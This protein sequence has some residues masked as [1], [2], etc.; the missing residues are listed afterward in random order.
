MIASFRRLAFSVLAAVLGAGLAQAAEH[1]VIVVEG[2]SFAPAADDGWQVIHQQQSYASHTYGGMWTSQGG[3]L[4]AEAASD[5]AVA[6][7][8]ITVPAAGK[9]RVWSKYQSPPYFNYRHRIEV[10][11]QGKLVFSQDYGAAGTDR[12]WSFSAGSDEL[13]WAWGVDHDAAEAPAAIAALAAGKAEV[14]LITIANPE[15]AGARMI[16]FVVLTT[17]PAD[18][19]IGRKPYRVGSPFTNEAFAAYQLYVRFKNTTG[20][21]AQANVSRRGHYQPS[22]GGASTKLPQ[23]EPGQWSAWHNI[24]PFCRLV[25]DEGLWVSVD[26]ARSVPLQFARDARG[27]K[28]VG[29]LTISSG[30][31][32]VVPL[33][34]AWRDGAVVRA[35]TDHAAA[36][37]KLART[38][39]RRA[40]DGRKPQ[41]ILFYGAFNGSEKWVHDLKDALGYNTLLPDSFDHAPVDG[42]F[43]HLPNEKAIRDYAQKLGNAA[44]KFRVC[45]LGDEIHIGRIDF[46]SEENIAGF[47]KWLNAKKVTESDLGMSPSKAVLTLNEP[48]QAWYTQRYNAERQF[49]HY[50]HLTEVARDAFGPQVLTGANY[51]PHY[52]VPAYFGPIYQWIDIFKHNGMSMFWAEDY[53]FSM[54]DL[55]QL[56]SWQFAQIRCAVKYH[57]QPIHFYVMPH[58]PGQEPGYFR[59]NSLLAIGAGARHIDNFWVAPPETFTENYV[60]WGYTDQFR[61]I[62]NSIFDTA[63]AEIC[64]VDAKPRRAQVAVLIGKATD[65]NETATKVPKEKD[66]FASRAKNA[67]Q[68]ITQQICRREAMMLYIALRHAG[69]EVDVITE[70]DIAERNE[71]APYKVVYFA[72]EWINTRSL[73][74]IEEW[75]AKGGIFYATAGCGLRNHFNALEPGS[76]KLLGLSGLDCRKD[77]YVLRTHFEL[78]VAKPIGKIGDDGTAVYGMQQKLQPTEAEVLYRWADGSVAA[79]LRKHGKGKIFAVG[80]LPGHTYVRTGLKRIPWGR[81]GAR[82]I[83]NPTQF[84]VAETKLVRLGLDA[85][86]VVPEVVCSQPLVE[87]WVLDNN[88]GTCLT[89]V[90]WTNEP[91]EG[92]EVAVRS[93][94]KPKRVRAVAM[95]KDLP[96]TYSEGRVRFTV[97]VPEADYI[98]LLK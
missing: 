74:P 54:G 36:I 81:G 37:T 16:D 51:S 75:V 52:P 95:Q 28:V 64:L 39:W 80:T 68:Q 14:R 73:K 66:P 65:E 26:G 34:I 72:G 97:E 23:A 11:Q 55:P 25:H 18:D 31:S 40:G 82:Q 7:S 76:A 77:N 69:V 20:A 89:L 96:F 1:S 70:D 90:N 44:R 13:F 22:Y 87:A 8:T 53:I 93:A 46:K 85:A 60:S 98:L 10:R 67:P 24:G 71:L 92:V 45:S 47:R 83:Y 17:N 50:R 6:T 2:E 29:D 41:H 59:R 30:A 86:D 9:Y 88:K 3:L 12:M 58:A 15:P 33:D 35:S 94:F 48:R 78:V 84:G 27:A 42:Y 32:V 19:Y 5:G 49:A 63:A 43:Q 57:N 91:A 38:K 61:A 4:S 62:H 79:T 21:A 56:I